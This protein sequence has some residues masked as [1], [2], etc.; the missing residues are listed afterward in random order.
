[1]IPFSCSTL[2][3]EEIEA[4]AHVI[5][6][7]WV[8]QG[9]K[10]KEFEE[11]FAEYIGAK[12]AVFVDSCTAA[13]DLSIK[14][15]KKNNSLRGI[16]KAIVPSLTFTSSAEVLVHNKLIPD[17]WDVDENLCISGLFPGLVIAVH[18]TGNECTAQGEVTI[19][20][21]AHRIE[22]NQCK[23][24]PNLVCFSFYATKNM[25]TVQGG[26]IATNDKDA[27]EWLK[28]ARD[29]GISK[30][31][32][33]RYKNGNWA[34]S[35]DFVG[36]REKS[37]DIHAAIGLEQLKKLDAM[38]ERR[39]AI[40]ERY[41][42]LFGYANTGN[43]LYPVRV[44]ERT[45]FIEKLKEAGIQT[46]VHF[47]PLHTMPAYKKYASISL[48]NTDFFGAHFVSLPLFPQLTDEEVEYIARTAKETGLLL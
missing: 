44:K 2:G 36:W 43:H 47:L 29:H 41:N 23:D 31:T 27:Y 3:E 30:G 16:K 34:Y 7:G 33:E 39:K 38:N 32:E 48:P 13:L 20:D 8:V 46:S 22:R 37:D 5:R 17:F 28:K 10:T 4:V 12:H 24:N 9:P 40:V 6:S 45:E 18:L 14:W 11:K 1:M 21:S 25:T 35:I 19:E 26:M 15:H 42:A